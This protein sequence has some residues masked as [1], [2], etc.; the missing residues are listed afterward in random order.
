MKLFIISDIHGSLSA[1]HKALHQFDNE[2]ADFMII[3][4]DYLNHGPRNNIPEGYDTKN[5]ALELNQIKE[6]IIGVR[7]NCDSDVDQ[8]LLEFP[9]LAPISNILLPN[10]TRV[11][12]HHGHLYSEEDCSKLL[13]ANSIVVSGH[14]HIPVLENKLKL[15][16]VNP[17]SVSIP[18]SDSKP[19][20]ALITSDAKSCEI[21][22]YSLEG[23]KLKSI[24]L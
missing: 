10:G 21:G 5:L 16:F 19:G 8:M 6:K 13:P 2:K 20:Y 7:G 18:K 4:G 12:V 3:C 24:S 23:E 9:V 11:F 14:T 22:I 17:G 1:F 15:T